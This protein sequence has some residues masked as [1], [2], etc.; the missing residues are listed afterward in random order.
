[1][2]P[3]APE[4]WMAY[5]P[6]RPPFLFVDEVTDYIA[7]KSL[8]SRTV[9]PASMPALVGH[10]PAQPIVPG[11]LLLEAIFQSGCILGLMSLEL[12]AEEAMIYLMGV[13]KAKFRMPVLPDS[14]VDFELSVVRGHG[15][16]WR[17][18]GSGSVGGKSAVE[19]RFMVWYKSKKEG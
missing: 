18:E 3:V 14:A 2:N 12:P 1:M 6:H 13:E 8:R 17:L 5:L 16:A 19:T 4:V 10:F 15:G 9:Y 7:L 11:V